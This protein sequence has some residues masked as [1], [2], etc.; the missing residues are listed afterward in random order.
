MLFQSVGHDEKMV[1]KLYRLDYISNFYDKTL[2]QV[3]NSWI[4]SVNSPLS[5]PY[6]LLNR[7][8]YVSHF[9]FL[10]ALV[11]RH[12]SPLSHSMYFL[13]FYPFLF[14]ISPF[15]WFFHYSSFTLMSR[16]L[17][18][19]YLYLKYWLYEISILVLTLFYILSEL[20][21]LHSLLKQNRTK[22]N[23]NINLL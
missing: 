22:Q 15:L 9:L 20:K 12:F 19:I 4:L 3:F 11:M 14:A 10:L 5:P 6:H 1:E 23:L 21:I 13:Y 17:H 7:S 18:I 16:P 8:L 2:K